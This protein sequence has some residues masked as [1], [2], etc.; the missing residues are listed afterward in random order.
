[1]S[2]FHSITTAQSFLP[3]LLTKQTTPTRPFGT[4]RALR[5]SP[6]FKQEDL[7]HP[8]E[9]SRLAARDLVAAE[10]RDAERGTGAPQC[11]THDEHCDLSL[12]FLTLPSRRAS[13]VDHPSRPRGTSLGFSRRRVTVALGTARPCVSEPPAGRALEGGAAQVL[14]PAGVSLHEV[15]AAPS[16]CQGQERSPTAAPSDTL[17]RAGRSWGQSGSPFRPPSARVAPAS[18]D[19]WH[20]SNC[21]GRDRAARFDF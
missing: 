11:G 14:R 3:P 13:S 5:L 20:R 12:H 16:S 1:V 4:R 18:P 19:S 21:T 6:L 9:R 17:S 10:R 15:G 8:L 7:R 2:R